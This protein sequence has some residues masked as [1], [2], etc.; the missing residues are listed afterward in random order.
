MNKD[1]IAGAAHVTKGAVKEKIGEIL[2]DASLKADGQAEKAA[3]R[4]QNAIG[5]AKDAIKD[6]LP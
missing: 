3:G 1:R 2:G 5:G 4:I 6:A